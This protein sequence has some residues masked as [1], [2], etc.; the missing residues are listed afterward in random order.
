LLKMAQ[1]RALVAATLVAAAASG[2]FTQDV[3]DWVL[4]QSAV[5]SSQGRSDAPA[6]SHSVARAATASPEAS[7]EGSTRAGGDAGLPPADRLLP[8]GMGAARPNGHGRSA[9]TVREATGGLPSSRGQLASAQAGVHECAWCGQ[10]VQSQS[11]ARTSL[12]RFGALLCATHFNARA[13]EEYRQ[14]S[15]GLPSEEDLYS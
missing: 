13:Q 7:A 2:I 4:D 15:A 5:G 14:E 6:A 9:G 1:K 3:E 12:T 8:T 10:P 11:L